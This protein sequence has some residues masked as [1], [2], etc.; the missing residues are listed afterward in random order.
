MRNTHDALVQGRTRTTSRASTTKTSSAIAA[1][2]TRS[3]LIRAPAIGE[4]FGAGVEGGRGDTRV[5]TRFPA[6]SSSGA[7]VQEVA[8]ELDPSSL[9]DLLVAGPA[10][11]HVGDDC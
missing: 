9:Q 11:A 3:T 5:E 6:G 8:Q 7:G 10:P 4:L 2:T 1:W